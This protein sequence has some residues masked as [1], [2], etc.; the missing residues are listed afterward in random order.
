[1]RNPESNSIEMGPIARALAAVLWP[2]FMSSVIAT[3]VFFANVDP[4][5]LRLATFPEWEI[6]QELGY[7]LGFFMFWAVTTLSSFLTLVLVQ[8]GSNNRTSRSPERRQS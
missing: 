8:R 2:A 5:T 6:S 1:M 4:E 3:A 7:T